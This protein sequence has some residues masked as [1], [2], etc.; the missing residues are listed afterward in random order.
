MELTEEQRKSIEEA[1]RTMWRDYE[2]G[3]TSTEIKLDTLQTRVNELPAFVEETNKRF[4]EVT[5][6][7]N[8]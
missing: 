6:I 5:S 8:K 1:L 3:N 7:N 2:D 4:E